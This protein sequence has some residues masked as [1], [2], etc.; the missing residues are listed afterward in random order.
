MVFTEK[1]V[2]D[3]IVKK[4]NNLKADGRI[5][6]LEYVKATPNVAGNSRK[7]ADPYTSVTP[8]IEPAVADDTVMNPAEGDMDMVEADV[9]P[10]YPTTSYD[11]DREA[12]DRDRRDRDR[13]RDGFGSSGRRD[14]RRDDRPREDRDRRRDDRDREDRGDRDRERERDRDFDRRESQPSQGFNGNP[15][16][17][18]RTPNQT[19][20]NGFGRSRGG[21]GYAG[22]N[23]RGGY[24]YNRAGYAP[25]RGYRG[26]YGR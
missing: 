24:G 4:F 20:G 7:N 3:R 14:D 12:A 18:Q 11:H 5:L 9:N 22:Y 23:S 21:N 13:D 1:S 19:Y 2:A 8:S 15:D 25:S 17:S 10:E 6:K 26:G 16:Y